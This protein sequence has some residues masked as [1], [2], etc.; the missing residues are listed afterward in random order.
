M[1]EITDSVDCRLDVCARAQKSSVNALVRSLGRS[2]IDAFEVRS[3]PYL[4][5]LSGS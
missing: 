3:C 5:T 4:K 1:A 2:E